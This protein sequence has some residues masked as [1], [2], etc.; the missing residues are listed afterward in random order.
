MQHTRGQEVM[1][2]RTVLGKGIQAAGLPSWLGF[3]I[4][5]LSE[6]RRKLVK[7]PQFSQGV[8]P[9]LEETARFLFC[10]SRRMVSASTVS[11]WAWAAIRSQGISQLMT[12]NQCQPQP[13]RN[14]R[15]LTS[16]PQFQNL[17]LERG[18]IKLQM[19]I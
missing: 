6:E 13:F 4:C 18:R 15:K 1:A 17:H 9:Q 19:A 5:I 2:V 7:I 12:L 11:L 10:S 3:Q 16:S 14:I 8:C